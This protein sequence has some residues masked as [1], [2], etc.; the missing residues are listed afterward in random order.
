MCFFDWEYISSAC[1]VI[2]NYMHQIDHRHSLE[3]AVSWSEWRCQLPVA[4]YICTSATI[5]SLRNTI[6]WDIIFSHPCTNT[7]HT[8]WGREIYAAC[9]IAS[10][11]NFW[12]YTRR[13]KLVSHTVFRTCSMLN[14]KYKRRSQ[15]AKATEN[16]ISIH[17]CTLFSL[18][19]NV[20][21]SS[22][23]HAQDHNRR[24]SGSFGSQNCCDSKFKKHSN[25]RQLRNAC[26]CVVKRWEI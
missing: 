24:H 15:L 10:V 13:L 21:S 1:S 7:Q 23:S 22:P 20:K 8:I 2:N 12:P 18:A 14:A 3:L 6:N 19:A 5:A 16:A 11:N 25:E 26:F 4:G 17:L 9:I